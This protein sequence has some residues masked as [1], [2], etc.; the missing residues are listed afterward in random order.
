MEKMCPICKNETKKLNVLCNS[1]NIG[2]RWVCCTC[3]VQNR[4]KV[5]EG[6]TSRSA[7]LRGIEHVN[8]L[9]GKKNDSVLYKHQLTEHENEEV[10]FKMEITGIFKDALS[11]QAEEAVRIQSRKPSEL[12]NS[13]SEFNHPP[14]ARIMVEKRRRKNENYGHRAQLSP[15]L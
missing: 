7:R 2:Y 9:A 14:I 5:Y 12:M 6:E 1:N 13:K 11:R 10:E 8:Q 15:S 4:T 3:E